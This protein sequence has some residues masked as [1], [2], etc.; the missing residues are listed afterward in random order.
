[1]AFVV[2]TGTGSA[3]ANSFASEVAADA[4]HAD[5]G[6]TAWAAFSPAVKQGYLIAA[7]DYLQNFAVF[8]W[9]GTVKTATQALAWPRTGVVETYGQAV[10]D[11]IV[12]YKVIQATADLALIASTTTLQPVGTTAAAGVK[13]RKVDVLEVEYF[14]EGSTTTTNPA[15]QTAAV[16]SA[17]GL[18]QSLLRTET[19]GMLHP[20]V[21]Y[22]NLPVRAEVEAAER[23]LF[24]VDQHSNR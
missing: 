8:P 21:P 17:M 5:R 11:T 7:T 18:V 3:T 6:N 22:A 9:K 2:E 24:Y 1:M 12:P 16:S 10:A 15:T 4:Y 14:Q 13:R 19:A 23:P 20:A